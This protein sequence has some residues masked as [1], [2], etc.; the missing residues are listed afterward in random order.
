MSEFGS[1]LDKQSS[2]HLWN[3]LLICHAQE[4][5]LPVYHCVV[6][7]RMGDPGGSTERGCL[8]LS[9]RQL[10]VPRFL[11]LSSKEVAAWFNFSG[12]GQILG[13]AGGA[14]ILAWH[15]S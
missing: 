3:G 2:K 4:I 7:V 1:S 10:L 15:C 8:D 12:D 5:S 6:I 14:A 11:G 9:R 13:R